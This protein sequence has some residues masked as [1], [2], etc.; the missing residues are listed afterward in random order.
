[1]VAGLVGLPGHHALAIGDREVAPALIH[2]LR[3]EVKAVLENPQ[4]RLNVTTKICNT[5]GQSGFNFIIKYEF[6]NIST[7]SH[8][9]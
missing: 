1:M 2:H 9:K 7:T 3:M 8:C 5:I 6:C 4:R